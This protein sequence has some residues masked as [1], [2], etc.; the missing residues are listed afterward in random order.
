MAVSSDI[1][2]TY[3]TYLEVAQATSEERIQR[4]RRGLPPALVVQLAHDLHIPDHSVGHFLGISR[5]TLRR[6]I[7]DDER[8]TAQESEGPLAMALLAGR[9]VLA[10]QQRT[11]GDRV[12][13]ADPLRWLGRWIRTP[14][15]DLEGRA[16]IQYMDVGEGRSLVAEWLTC[17]LSLGEQP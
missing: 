6:R 11:S 2:A 14:V 3:A 9:V 8:L 16:P 10:C 5:A 15:P 7:A 17:A 1:A 4:V 12:T 13:A